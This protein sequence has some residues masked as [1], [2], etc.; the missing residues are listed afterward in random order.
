MFNLCQLNKYSCFGCCGRRWSN[1]QEVLKQIEKNTKAFMGMSKKDFSLR[2]EVEFSPSGGCKSLVFREKKI[3]G[4]KF[5][6]IF[7][8]SQ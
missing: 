6:K 3:R 5:A 1:E 2:G 7:R 4:V 8:F